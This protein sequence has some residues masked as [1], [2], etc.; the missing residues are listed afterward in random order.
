MADGARMNL[1]L[2][3]HRSGANVS[4]LSKSPP[5]PPPAAAMGKDPRD[6]PPETLIRSAPSGA[7]PP[8]GRGFESEAKLA[9]P[10]GRGCP[11]SSSIQAEGSVRGSHH[12]LFVR[13]MPAAQ[14]R[15]AAFANVQSVPE[16]SFSLLL[17]G[18]GT[19]E[20]GTKKARQAGPSN[21]VGARLYYS[22]LSG[23]ATD[24][25]ISLARFITCCL[26]SL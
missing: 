9:S 4:Y 25:K 13:S 14:W 1:N 3:L 18:S 19:S 23:T 7:G 5:R 22:A 6:K 20:G 21:C 15:H 16:P 12:A 17:A 11:G 24:R 2:P 10:P 8:S 26:V